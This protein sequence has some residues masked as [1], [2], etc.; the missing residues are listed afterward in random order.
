MEI[1]IPTPQQ[2]KDHLLPRLKES[3]WY[4]KMRMYLNGSEF[5]NLL[6]S[7]LDDYRLNYRLTPR[8]THLFRAFELTKPNDVRVV[9]YTQDLSPYVNK[10]TG[11]AYDQSFAGRVDNNLRY[12][13]R[14]LEETVPGFKPKMDLSYLSQQGVLLLPHALSTTVDSFDAHVE[15]WRGFMNTVFSVFKHD[16]DQDV[17]YV[18]IGEKVHVR[19]QDLLK[20]AVIL[21]TST[22]VSNMPN[23]WGSNIFNLINENLKLKGKE[24]IKW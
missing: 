5:E 11:I 7:L 3:G 16:L 10:Y 14:E 12:F 15:L 8:L 18:L 6:N 17:V 22:P 1:T 13:L 2:I 19:E 20:N 21:K 24:T 4:D 23:G 9:L